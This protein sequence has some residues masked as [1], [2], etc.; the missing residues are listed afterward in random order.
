MITKQPDSLKKALVK[1][2]KE[3]AYQYYN[4][5]PAWSYVVECLSDAEIADLIGDRVTTVKGA[6]AQVYAKYVK[7]IALQAQECAA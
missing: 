5:Y 2:V 4:K 3:Q 7:D 6:V 1:A